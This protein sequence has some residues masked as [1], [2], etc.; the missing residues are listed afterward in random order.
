VVSVVRAE[1]ELV[2]IDMA[3]CSSSATQHQSLKHLKFSDYA[4]PKNQSFIDPTGERL[5]TNSDFGL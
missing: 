5:I 2:D 3:T 4:R 1:Q